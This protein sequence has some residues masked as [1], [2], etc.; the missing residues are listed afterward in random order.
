MLTRRRLGLAAAGAF[1]SAQV[2][3]QT[4]LGPERALQ[5]GLYLPPYLTYKARVASKP[6]DDYA[7]Q[8]LQWYAAY[9][10]AEADALGDEPGTGP[11]IDLRAAEAED[12]IAA[13]AAAAKDKRLVILNEA[14]N[15][16]GH[17]SFA[18]AVM[19]ALRPVGF[20]VFAAET[21]ASASPLGYPQVSDF[22]RHKAFLPSYGFYTQDPVFAETV[23]E[24]VGLCYA[25]ASYEITAEQSKL[26]TTA[27]A[28]DSIAEREE[29]QAE[30]VLALLQARPEARVFVYCGYSHVGERMQKTGEWFAARLKRKFGADPLTIEQSS[31]WPAVRPELDTP[32]TR[33]VLERFKPTKPIVVT[34]NGRPLS[35]RYADVVD[36]AVHHPRLPAVDGRPGWLATDP[37]RR[38]AKVTAPKVEGPALLQALHYSEGAS[39]VPADQ[40]LLAPGQREAAFLLRPG[41]YFVRVE[42]EAGQ[43]VLGEVKVDSP[44]Q[45]P[46]P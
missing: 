38:P 2:R 40:F 26:P 14:H 44:P 37:K 43:R 9:V 7:Q 1:A 42:T 30:N 39:G 4:P 12:A 3:A 11:R 32:L 20:D 22:G 24:A 41:T 33:A 27:S 29:A 25:L 19:R 28:A 35:N 36:L 46:A 34:Q 6:G 15:I 16:S 5:A 17:R 8:A 18:A 21:F 23:R 13:I 10:G 31:G 45:P